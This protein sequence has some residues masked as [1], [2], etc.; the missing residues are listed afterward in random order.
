MIILVLA[1]LP[2][3]QQT[4]HKS[5]LEMQLEV[6]IILVFAILPA[7]QQTMHKKYPTNAIRSHDDTGPHHPF[8][9]SANNG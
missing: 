9:F 6:I 7:I 8:C 5:T 3:I 2:A 4:M 1:I